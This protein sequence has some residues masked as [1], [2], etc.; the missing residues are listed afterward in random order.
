MTLFSSARTGLLCFA[1]AA[2]GVVTYQWLL[3][4]PDEARESSVAHAASPEGP[5]REQVGVEESIQNPGSR[6]ASTGNEQPMA[7]AA[8][9]NASAVPVAQQAEPWEL[10]AQPIPA[11]TA[12]FEKK[13]AGWTYDE[14][15]E[16]YAELMSELQGECK[17]AFQERHAAGL[18]QWREFEEVTMEDENGET[19]PV[20][21]FRVRGDSH[22]LFVQAGSDYFGDSLRPYAVWLPADQYPALYKKRDELSWIN[23]RRGNLKMAGLGPNPK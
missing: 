20:G 9:L 13:Y 2:T 15:G 22:G 18:S 17:A 12:P 16:S 10:E 4:N 5:N 23:V 19:Q 3:N 8:P 11:S 7:E 14:L 6:T 1:C 21:S